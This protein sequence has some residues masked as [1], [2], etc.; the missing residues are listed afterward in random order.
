MPVIVHVDYNPST[1]AIDEHWVLVVGKQGSDY[2]INDP[3]DGKQHKFSEIYGD[4]KSKI[5]HV[6]T[7]NYEK[8]AEPLYRV[9]VTINNLLIRGGPG[10]SYPVVY[11]Y[12]SGEYDVFEERNGYGRIGA[13]RWISL[14]YTER[15]TVEPTLTLEQRVTALE[16]AVFGG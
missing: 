3:R 1:P 6:C 2:I 14:A 16:K 13:G 11:R 5:Y 7:Y 10:T 15:I 9:R 4:P 12:A 8:V